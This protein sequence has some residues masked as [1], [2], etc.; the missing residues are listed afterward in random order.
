[1]RN[2][3]AVVEVISSVV[4]V[5]IVLT[6]ISS[7]MLWGVPYMTEIE[8]KAVFENAYSKLS[9]A[10]NAIENVIH[11]TSGSSR[12]Y[13]FDVGRGTV[14]ITKGDRFIVSYSLDQ[15]YDFVVSGLGDDDGIFEVKIIQQPAGLHLYTAV[16]YRFD[17]SSEQDGIEEIEITEPDQNGGI[18]SSSNVKFWWET[19]G[20]FYSYRLNGYIDE[21]SSWSTDTSKTYYNLPDRD[22]I[23]EVDSTNTPENPP[24][25]PYFGSC[26]FTVIKG[27]LNDELLRKSGTYPDYQ[28]SS[29]GSLT[30]TIRIDLYYSVGP[31][32]EE[33]LFGR[34]LLFDLG[35][36][37]H[38]Y[39]TTVGTY[40]TLL[41]NNAILTIKPDV[42]QVKKAPGVSL[43][44]D[45]LSFRMV[46]VR[47]PD[48][49]Y[50][51]GSGTLRFTSTFVENYVREMFSDVHNVKLQVYG[52]YED[53]WLDYFKQSQPFGQGFGKW[54]V[55]YEDVEDPTNGHTLLPGYDIGNI[56]LII[57]QSLCN[58]GFGL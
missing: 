18:K 42:E 51:G 44:D 17:E 36:V 48:N 16:V 4:S 11:E 49:Y 13:T 29:R 55:V 15:D 6:V 1:M 53:M 37:E 38:V 14:S 7:I 54:T 3:Y 33:I 34:V 22:Y 25:E 28:F 40:V 24:D 27:H 43:G 20:V 57:T 35:L 30:G 23:F 32:T 52:P 56:R 8:A 9:A 21:W 50:I 12:T 31:S 58:V 2:N 10:S 39:P 41:E 47:C 19:T 26:E 45:V 5:F 46:Q